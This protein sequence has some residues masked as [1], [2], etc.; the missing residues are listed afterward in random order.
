MKGKQISYDI[1]NL[2]KNRLARD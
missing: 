1:I 2:W